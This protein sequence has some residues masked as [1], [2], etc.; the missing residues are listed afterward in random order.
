MSRAFE[1]WHRDLQ[2][3]F[4]RHNGET[5]L[6]NNILFGT[7]DSVDSIES[8]DSIYGTA[9][10]RGHLGEGGGEVPTEGPP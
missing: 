7:V 9:R 2:A 10:A 4:L 5:T 3:I 1:I 6:A 8:I